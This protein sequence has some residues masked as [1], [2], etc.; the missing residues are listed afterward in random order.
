MNMN[1][2]YPTT[3]YKTLSIFMLYNTFGILTSLVIYQ[4]NPFWAKMQNDFIECSRKTL[5]YRSKFI[6]MFFS[7]IN[8]KCQSDANGIKPAIY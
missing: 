2:S 6:F 4:E 7:K 5:V 1:Y 8:P 3:I